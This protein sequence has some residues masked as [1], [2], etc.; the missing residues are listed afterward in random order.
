MFEVNC[1]RQM[2]QHKKKNL[3]PNVELHLQVEL[4]RKSARDDEND[5]AH[6]PQQADDEDDN[7]LDEMP[8]VDP[9]TLHCQHV[10]QVL[11]VVVQVRVQRA[12]S[13]LTSKP[14][15]STHAVAVTLVLI[16]QVVHVLDQLLHVTGHVLAVAP[17][18]EEEEEEEG[19]GLAQ[20][21]DGERLESLAFV[22]H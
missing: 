17:V 9:L 11:Q 15:P 4:I 20:H 5:E 13:H 7:P 12:L 14:R 22:Q 3:S 6:Q 18:P 8:R 1:S 19:G 16:G 2:G 10:Q 21:Q